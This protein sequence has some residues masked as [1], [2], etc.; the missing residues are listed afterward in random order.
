MMVLATALAS[1]VGGVAGWAFAMSQSGIDLHF[2]M[3]ATV[4]GLVILV[5]GGTQRISFIVVAALALGVAERI[6]A[7]I[8]GTGYRDLL[9]YGLILA[10]LAI[11]P[12][13]RFSS[14][15]LGERP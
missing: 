11:E 4:K 2:G 14:P 1:S 6:G 3:W 10:L 12:F 15:R 13:S 5:L 8:I 7:E 9:G